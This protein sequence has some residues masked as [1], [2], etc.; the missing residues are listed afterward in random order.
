MLSGNSERQ[1]QSKLGT[2]LGPAELDTLA[3]MVNRCMRD[4]REIHMVFW[5]TDLAV[6]WGTI[7]VMT[8]YRGLFQ[9]H[10]TFC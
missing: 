7:L 2:S 6:L 1:W 8:S 4:A 5:L 10:I 3:T 9:P